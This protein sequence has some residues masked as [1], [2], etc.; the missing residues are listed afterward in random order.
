MTWKQRGGLLGGFVEG[1][2]RKGSEGIGIWTE[3]DGLSVCEDV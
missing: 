1:E 3:Y 2:L